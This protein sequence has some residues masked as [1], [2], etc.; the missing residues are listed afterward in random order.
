[1]AVSYAWT[2]LAKCLDRIGGGAVDRPSDVA[3]VRRDSTL[4]ACF[5]RT[6]TALRRGLDPLRDPTP[7]LAFKCRD[8]RS[9]DGRFAAFFAALDF[10]F[11]FV[12]MGRAEL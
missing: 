9:T 3:E 8:L 2:A 1:M 4:S 12:A 6:A 10:D 11:A 5:A 7:A